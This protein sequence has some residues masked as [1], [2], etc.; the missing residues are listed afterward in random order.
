MNLGNCPRCGRLYA[1]NFR[2]MC[3]ECLKEIEKEYEKCATFLR[4]QKGATIHEVSEATEVSIRQITRFIREGRISIANAPNMAYPCEVCG[5]LIRESNMCE[6]CRTRLTRE[7][8]QAAEADQ[9][10]QPG[11]GKGKET[12][13]AVDKL[14]K[15]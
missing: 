6:S 2:D 9:D 4:E 7:L 3:S 1:L 15:Y 8:R 11:S 14:R 13:R 5:T 12:Y 10:H